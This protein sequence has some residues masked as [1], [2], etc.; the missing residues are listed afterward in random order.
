MQIAAMRG[1]HQRFEFGARVVAGCEVVFQRVELGFQDQQRPREAQTLGAVAQGLDARDVIVDLAADVITAQGKGLVQVRQSRL[2][3]GQH[4]YVATC[5]ACLHVGNGRVIL[6]PIGRA[7]H[8]VREPA[9]EPHDGFPD[10]VG[11]P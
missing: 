9:P 11:K 10:A 2:T 5:R 4:V 3:M 6:Q 7:R 8:L 1:A